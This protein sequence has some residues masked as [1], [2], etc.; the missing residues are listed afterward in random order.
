MGRKKNQ[1]LEKGYNYLHRKDRLDYLVELSNKLTQ[2]TFKSKINFFGIS[3]NVLEKC[4]MQFL[5]QRILD[6]NFNEQILIALSNDQKKI[7]LGLPKTWLI[8]L[9]NEGFKSN[10]L[11]NNLSWMFFVLWWYAA[12][13]YT[14]LKTF[15]R[16]FLTKTS[17]SPS[18]VYFDNLS[19]NNIPSEKLKSKTIIDW[20]LSKFPNDQMEILHD[21]IA[22]KSV[23]IRK[24]KI[25][26]SKFPFRVNLSKLEWF[27]FLVGGIWI[28]IKSLYALIRGDFIQALLLKEYPLLNLAKKTSNEMFGKKYLFHNSVRIFRPLWTYIAKQK[29][30]DVILY[31]Y[32]TNNSPLKFNKGYLNGQG[33]K[34]FMS[35]D[36]VWAWNKYQKEYLK[37]YIPNAK[38]EIVGPI[39]FSS[40]NSKLP[41]VDDKLKIVS[42]FDIQTVKEEVYKSYGFPDRYLTTPNI[43][44]FHRDIIDVFKSIDNVKVM[45]KR[46]RTFIQGIHDDEYIEYIQNEYNNEKYLQVDSNLDAFTLIKNSDL[47]ISIPATSTAYMAK[48]YG[49]DSIYYDPT[50]RVNEKD[51]ALCGVKLISGKEELKNH[52][53]KSM[54]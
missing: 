3:D 43:I 52:I 37:Q 48:Y 36:K 40:N 29:G 19:H 17:S 10:T 50:E 31:Y 23:T 41:P 28:S 24:T 16:G 2:K 9:E 26:P 8:E 6:A 5:I 35:W 18:Y 32:S 14:I 42:I 47:S 27:K 20:Y 25:S 21:A 39:W 46:K 1:K 34:H 12:G 45:L 30:A 15:I 7:N 4:A 49:Q 54:Q 38:I 22:Q 51:R 44:Q 13:V 53:L 33:N 11:K